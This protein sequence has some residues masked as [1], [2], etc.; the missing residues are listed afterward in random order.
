MKHTT[1]RFKGHNGLELFWQ[2]WHPEQEAKGTLVLVHGVGEHSGRYENLIDYL[3]D[4]GFA[5]YGYDLRGHGRSPG[6]K[7]FIDS[8]EEYRQDLHLFIQQLE[9]KIHQPFLMGHSLG[10]LIALDYASVHPQAVRGVVASSPPISL[11]SGSRVLRYVAIVLNILLPKMQFGAPFKPADLSRIPAVV[12]AYIDDPLV[13]NRITA[14]WVIE[15]LRTIK[16]L[17]QNAGEM[18]T[19]A[20]LTHGEADKVVPIDGTRSFYQIL[21]SEDKTFINYPESRHEPHNDSNWKEAVENISN[22]L[23]ERLG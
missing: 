15:G 1:G 7:G 4:R 17:M 6:R 12:Q 13:H 14:R 10:G 18:K 8:W 9:P 22:W 16:T 23:E 2:S 5:V 21:G 19:P 20:L 3:V 11:I